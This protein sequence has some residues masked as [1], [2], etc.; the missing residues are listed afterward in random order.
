MDADQPR[1]KNYDVKPIEDNDYLLFYCV[2]RV[3]LPWP[4]GLREEV[5]MPWS[6]GLIFVLLT[7][8]VFAL[9]AFPQQ[10]ITRYVRFSQAGQISYG[11]IEG[12]KILEL[13]GNFLHSSRTTG[14]VLQLSEVRLLA[15][16]EPSKVIAVGL[17]YKSHLG[18]RPKPAQPGLFAKY[19]TSIIG[20]GDDIVFP[21]G[22]ENVHYEGEVVIVIG[23]KAHNVTVGEAPEHIFG[24]TAGNDVS[25]RNWQ[26]DDL[27][28]LRAKASDT[29]GPIGP[30]VSR[31]LNYNDVLLQT[32][33]NGEVRQSQ[34]TRDLIFDTHEIVSYV[35][36]FITLMP[37]DLI[38]TGTPGQTAA[39]KAGDVVEVEIE[40]V[41]VLRNRV[42]SKPE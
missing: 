3:N 1:S 32:R 37:G 25:E 19:P 23:K 8:G 24:I 26:R 9:S 31:G 29:F 22:A 5:A 34:R 18:N 13:D 41:G 28:W 12:D 40:G 35:S 4:P 21:P 27:Q 15:P 30:V 6:H 10:E 14:K 20:P 36:R 7:C 38:F 33:L 39:M 11:I 17:N 2:S 16:C 42:V